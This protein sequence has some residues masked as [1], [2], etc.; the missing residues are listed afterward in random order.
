MASQEKK[1]PVDV[2]DLESEVALIFGFKDE[3]SA[4]KIANQFSRSNE[5]LKILGG[6]FENEFINR[7]KVIVLAEIPSQEELLARFVG[8]IKAPIANF[9]NV[10]Q[11]NIKGLTYILSNIKS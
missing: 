11:G 1:I 4:A 9:A 2:K 6:V 8:S 5:N 3:L 7:E 10:L